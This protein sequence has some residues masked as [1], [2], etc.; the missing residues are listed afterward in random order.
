MSRHHS[1]NI[2]HSFKLQKQIKPPRNFWRFFVPSRLRL[3][4]GV[5]FARGRTF[6]PFR[7][8]CAT[9]RNL[10]HFFPARLDTLS[11]ELCLIQLLINFFSCRKHAHIPTFHSHSQRDKIFILLVIHSV[12]L[13]FQGFLAFIPPRSERSCVKTNPG[14][15]VKRLT[16]Q[17]G[18]VIFPHSMRQ[19][20]FD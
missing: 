14:D 6:L 16:L 4:K 7:T 13:S 2:F 20:N 3:T 9:A 15:S 5:D 17:N 19:R 1:K 10:F 18:S 11:E 8:T 12:V